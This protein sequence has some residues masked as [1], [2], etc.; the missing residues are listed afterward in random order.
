MK[1]IIIIFFLLLAT[2]A[3]AF[4]FLSPDVFN[5]TIQKGESVFSRVW[6]CKW[7]LSC[8]KTLGAFT[9]ITSTNTISGFPTIYNLNL[10]KTIEVATSSVASITTL[11]NL[12]TVGALSSGSLASGFTTVTAALGGTGSTTL[13]QYQIL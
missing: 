10:T 4:E 11:S 8:Y 7:R 6:R 5:I 9:T 13:S 3:Y 12:V 1:K 2:N